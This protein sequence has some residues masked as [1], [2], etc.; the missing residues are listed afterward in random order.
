MWTV[1]RHEL[2]TRF[3]IFLDEGKK[4]GN[5][6]FCSGSRTM[7]CYPVIR[8]SNSFWARGG[9]K[10]NKMRLFVLAGVVGWMVHY[11]TFQF[12]KMVETLPMI[13]KPHDKFF[14]AKS[15]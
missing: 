13:S 1:F 2:Q 3:G 7:N 8:V 9:P 10:R 14:F 4:R 5:Q 11:P 6:S 12:S 15:G